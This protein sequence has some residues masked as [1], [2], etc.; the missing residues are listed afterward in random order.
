MPTERTTPEEMREVARLLHR[1]G[2]DPECLETVRGMLN[3]AADLATQIKR[4]TAERE[5]AVRQIS[6][7]SDDRFAWKKRA[8]AAEAERDAMRE[9]LADARPIFWRWAS[10]SGMSHCLICNH[11]AERHDPVICIFPRIDAL[12]TKTKEDRDEDLVQT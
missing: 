2:S 1:M 9:V 5:E 3:E 11:P 10:C 7:I 6:R 4:L 12:L 8:T